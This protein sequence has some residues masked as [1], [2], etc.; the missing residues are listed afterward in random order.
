MNTDTRLQVPS[1]FVVSSLVDGL[2]QLLPNSM[3]KG[4]PADIS[5]GSAFQ[6]SFVSQNT[7]SNSISQVTPFLSIVPNLS[8]LLTQSSMFCAG[9]GA[10]D[11]FT[12]SVSVNQMVPISC[13]VTPTNDTSVLD[14]SINSAFSACGLGQFLNA[15]MVYWDSDCGSVGFYPAYS[16]LVWSLT[17]NTT[18]TLFSS[19]SFLQTT[20]PA[21]GSWEDLVHILA[22]CSISVGAP[23]VQ[24]VPSNATPDLLPQILSAVYPGEFPAIVFPITIHNHDDN[25]TMPLSSEV[26]ANNIQLQSQ[27]SNLTFIGG[28]DT[29]L[30]GGVVFVSGLP[31]MGGGV[32]ISV[33]TSFTSANQTMQ[34]LIPGAPNN[35]FVVS[36]RA[37]LRT[38]DL[39]VTPLVLEHSITLTPGTPALTAFSEAFAQQLPPLAKPLVTVAVYPALF[40]NLPYSFDQILISVSRYSLNNGSWVI[41]LSLTISD[42]TIPILSNA[43]IAPVT[44]MMLTENL[45]MQAS[46]T[47][48]GENSIA[49]AGTLGVLDVHFSQISGGGSIHLEAPTH[50]QYH[51]MISLGAA[52]GSQF[53]DQFSIDF[54]VS[55]KLQAQDL[56]VQYADQ[57]PAGSSVPFELKGSYSLDSSSDTTNMLGDLAKWT[58]NV[59]KPFLE[60]AQK[61]E[62]KAICNWA[63]LLEDKIV[64][65]INFPALSTSPLPFVSASIGVAFQQGIG[66]AISD[67]KTQICESPQTITLATMCKIMENSLG[68]NPCG[69]L[70]LGARI[71]LDLNII[72][73]NYSHLAAFQMDTHS[74]FGGNLPLTLGLSDSISI[75]TVTE[76]DIK[77][78]IDLSIGDQPN[79]TLGPAATVTLSVGFSLT[80]SVVTS[81]GPLQLSFGGIQMLLGG[82]NY[83]PS[84]AVVTAKFTEDGVNVQIVGSAMMNAQTLLLG[85]PI[86]QFAVKVPNIEGYLRNPKGSGLEVDYPNCNGGFV[87]QIVEAIE[88][89]TLLAFFSQ[90]LMLIR[91]IERA[92]AEFLD[93]VFGIHGIVGDVELPL[94]GKLV[95]LIVASEINAIVG[96]KALGALVSNIGD[97]TSALEH[98]QTL[99]QTYIDQLVL[100]GITKAICTAFVS[101]GLM[102]A[103]HCPAV[104]PVSADTYAWPIHLGRSASRQTELFNFK[105]G[106]HGFASLNSQ[107]AQQLN[108]GWQ[109]DFTLQ[110]SRK[111]G[112]SV[113]FSTQPIFQSDINLK[114][115]DCLLFGKIGFMAAEFIPAGGIQGKFEVATFQQATLDFNAQISGDAD[116]GFTTN[117][118]ELT[119][120]P[121]WQVH[122]GFQWGWSLS[123]R[124]DAPHFTVSQGKVCAGHYLTKVLTEVLNKAQVIIKPMESVL[125][126]NSILL[127]PIPVVKYIIGHQL[128]FLDFCVMIVR[129]FCHSCYVHGIEAVEIFLRVMNTLNDLQNLIDNQCDSYLFQLY[130]KIGIYYVLV[131]DLLSY[132][133]LKDF[134]LDF[135][136]ASPN[137]IIQSSQPDPPVGLNFVPNTPAA[138]NAGAF[139]QHWQ[140]FNGGDPQFG[141]NIL[142]C[143]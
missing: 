133:Q 63:T 103:G 32:N 120:F 54:N 86:C 97:V 20:I 24:M 71:M 50:N 74:I 52:I 10:L 84:P 89:N 112:L 39:R 105:L 36:I 42:P 140:N 51:S 49:M 5:A 138:Q 99:N 33:I 19:P 111:D 18:S 104:P 21:F 67:V 141:V 135:T 137:N 60:T 98:V 76:L 1:T 41:P 14:V 61:L 132:N 12:L 130:F 70:T 27:N 8:P 106:N 38:P 107:C 57:I 64:K 62:N 3:S 95:E 88:K 143:L 131:F 96:P 122:V 91:G 73:F 35:T 53:Y 37:E 110:Y 80:G 9:N 127:K 83:A 46:T 93:V 22:S 114:L 25:I 126:P 47:L 28:L 116:F 82:S 59:T 101:S 78:D 58:V 92:V 26:V 40:P 11:N 23:V 81:L 13:T 142:L 90:P 34:Y 115:A 129:T 124:Q 72:G 125:G 16:G 31:P 134:A 77:L 45:T 100:Q 109:F 118:Q 113:Q 102:T 48:T 87:Q 30:R 4:G 44:I 121:Y 69:D 55:M 6:S 136:Q 29:I 94:V 119:M 65:V 15:E 7:F 108:V 123:N 43:T 128:T 85:V 68:F 117:T 79:V 139:Q 2:F 17:I 56:S 66:S 75:N